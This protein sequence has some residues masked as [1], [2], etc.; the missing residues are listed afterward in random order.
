VRPLEKTCLKRASGIV[1]SSSAL[2]DHSPL[3]TTWRHKVWVIPFG[4]PTEAWNFVNGDSQGPFLFVGRLVYYKG[5]DLLLDAV[6]QV[7]KAELVVVGDGPLRNKLEAQARSEGLA[8]RVRFTGE[9]SDV[10]LQAEMAR[11]CALVLPSVGPSETFGLVQLEAMAAGLPVVSTS[12]P[13]GVSEVNRDRVT[14]RVVPPGNR[15]ALVGALTELKENPTQG[16]VWGR[17]GRQLVEEM[18][19]RSAM[20]AKLEK[21]YEDLLARREQSCP[22]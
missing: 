19:T 12:L 11:A 21:C 15:Q 16:Q 14:G 22:S 13:T 10:A 7:P 18:Y 5:L 20:V 8:E 9:I 2:R 4:I 3:L 1:V 17:V 6:S